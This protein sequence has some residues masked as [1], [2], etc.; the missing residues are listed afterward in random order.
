MEPSHSEGDRN[1]QERSHQDVSLLILV[2]PDS[3]SLPANLSP[4]LSLLWTQGPFVHLLD[5]C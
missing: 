4:I 1:P 2:S 5:L 3:P